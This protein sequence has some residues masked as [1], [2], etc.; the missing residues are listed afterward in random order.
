[1]RI[2]YISLAL[3]CINIAITMVS[4]SEIFVDPITGIPLFDL[5]A[6]EG[7][8]TEVNKYQDSSYSSAGVEE[9]SLSFGFG[10]FVR[11]FSFFVSLIVGSI[12]GIGSMLELIGID[13]RLAF[14]IKTL[15]F[16]I[17]AA[18]FIQFISGRYFSRN[19][20]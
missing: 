16:F 14:L 17:Y 8:D 15:T 13:F 2:Y 7:Y 19:S 1:M 9:S 12:T 10:D 11:A 4:M 6:Q 3:F 20:P 5:Q 18:A